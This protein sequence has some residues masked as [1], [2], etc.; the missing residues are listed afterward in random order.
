LYGGKIFTTGNGNMVFAGIVSLWLLQYFFRQKF[1]QRAGYEASIQFLS[2]FTPLNR[3]LL[4][5]TAAVIA[6]VTLV[7]AIMR[8]QLYVEV[9]LPKYEKQDLVMLLDRSVSMYASDVLPSRFDRAIDEIKGFLIEKPADID[10]VAL[11]GF[12]NTAITLSHFSRDL[13]TLFFFLDWIREDPQ[14][15]YGTN[16]MDALSAGREM[17][18]KDNQ[19]TRKIFLILSDGDDQSTEL[20]G[21]LN[22]LRQEGIRIHSIGIGSEKAVPIPLSRGSETSQYLENEQGEQMSTLLDETTLRLVASTTTGSFF[23]SVTGR[24]L[25]DTI[26]EILMEGRMQTGWHHSQQYKDI[27]LPLLLLSCI[28]SFYLILRI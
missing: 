13:D 23:R 8:P 14:I 6:S 20:P 19:A 10:R 2:K 18:Q 9:L 27:H 24:E 28:F 22:E 12:A 26:G 17:V 21:L 5:L 4:I 25:A 15:Y 16:I 11:I 1:R 3:D 7:L